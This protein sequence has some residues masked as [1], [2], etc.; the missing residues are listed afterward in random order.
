MKS[1]Q[2]YYLS[3]L[4]LSGCFNS[5]HDDIPTSQLVMKSDLR[6]E[7]ATCCYVKAKLL[8]EDG[9][10]AEAS[11]SYGYVERYYLETDIAAKVFHEHG[12]LLLKQNRLEEAFEK[13]K[14]VTKNYVNYG[15]YDQVI[16]QEFEIACMLMKRFETKSHFPERR[17]H[18]FAFTGFRGRVFRLPPR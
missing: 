11:K 9:N 4:L 6:E 2:K 17:F 7:K 16:L 15:E 8:E 12:K 18:A 10:F 13:L 1:F 14:F 3:F 5:I